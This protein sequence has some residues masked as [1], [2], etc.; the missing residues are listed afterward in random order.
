MS[1]CAKPD[2]RASSAFSRLWFQTPDR[3][4]AEEMAAKI[5]AMVKPIFLTASI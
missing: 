1:S 4:P 5:E 3:I 2:T